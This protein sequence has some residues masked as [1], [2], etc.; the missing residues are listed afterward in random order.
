MPFG[1]FTGVT[2]HSLS[3]CAAGALLRDETCLSFDTAPQTILIDNDLSM[4]DA[5]RFALTDK[6]NTK[7]SLC[8]CE[9]EE[10]WSSIMVNENY[11]EARSYLKALNQFLDSKTTITD[12]LAAFEQAL[13]VHEEAEHISAY[14]ELVYLSRSTSQN[15]IKN[16][17][18]K[19]LT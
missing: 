7:H 10:R 17:V 9:F 8:I 3:Y 4:A 5:I 12:F 14:K 2:N 18:T 19:C 1:V 13:E 11:A 16:Q 15:P 6:Y